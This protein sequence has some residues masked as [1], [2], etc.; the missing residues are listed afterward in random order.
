MSLAKE[1]EESVEEIEVGLATGFKVL[2]SLGAKLTCSSVEAFFSRFFELK[3][4][5]NSILDV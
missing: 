5:K 4:T 1:V 2:P 3:K